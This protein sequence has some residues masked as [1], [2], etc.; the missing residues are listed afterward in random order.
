M[1]WL[2][3]EVWVEYHQIIYLWSR[4]CLHIYYLNS[5]RNNA[6]EGKDFFT[7]DTIR[8]IYYDRDWVD[9][10][11]SPM[12]NISAAQLSWIEHSLY[13]KIQA[14]KQVIDSPYKL[15]YKFRL[16]SIN[17]NHARNWKNKIKFTWFY[18]IH[19]I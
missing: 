11:D 13:H 2:R 3:M 4:L 7:M 8:C 1:R 14:T 5:N 19:S 16:I 10:I 18:D 15:K 12:V 6:A 17:P 9:N